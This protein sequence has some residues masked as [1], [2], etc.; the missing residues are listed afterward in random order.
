MSIIVI[1][2]VAGVSLGGGR[3]V[4]VCVGGG[5]GGVQ[6]LVLKMMTSGWMEQPGL[7][8][9]RGNIHDWC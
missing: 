1:R 3:G 4:G 6:C 9:A 5:C 2:T 8:I 7:V